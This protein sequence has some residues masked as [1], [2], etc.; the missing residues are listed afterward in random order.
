MTKYGIYEVSNGEGQLATISLEYVDSGLK[1]RL[2]GEIGDVSAQHLIEFEELNPYTYVEKTVKVQNKSNV[3]LP[4]QWLLYKPQFAGSTDEEDSMIVTRT[5]VLDSDTPFSIRPASGSLL[6]LEEAEFK[7]IFSPPLV[8]EYQNALHMLLNHL[9]PGSASSQQ[10]VA[11]DGN[12]IEEEKT[13]DTSSTHRDAMKFKDV[14]AMEIEVKGK[15]VPLNVVLHPYAIYIPG[16]TLVG[17]SVKKSF[18]M[19][20][21]SY[22]TITFQFEPH[23]DGHIVEVEPPCGDLDPGMAIDLEI[24]VTGVKPGKLNHTIYCQVLNMDQPLPLHVEGEFKGPEI[25]VE[26]PDVNFGLIRLGETSVR[27]I[28]L[29]NLSQMPTKW[30]INDFITSPTSSEDSMNSEEV[31]FYPTHGELKPLERSKV[32]ITFKPTQISTVHRVFEVEVEDGEKCS[33]GGY[34]EVQSPAVCFKQSEIK[35]QDVY[36]GVPVLCQAVLHNQTLMSTQFDWEKPNGVDS[37]NCSIEI[38]PI[39]GTMAPKEERVV[40]I[41]FVASQVGKVNDLKI[42]CVIEGMDEPLCLSLSCE[43]LGLSVTCKTSDSQGNISEELKVDFGNEVQLGSTP[44]MYLYICNQTAIPASYSITVENFPVRPPSPPQQKL[45]STGTS[46]R[47]AL[48]GR[49]PIV[50]DPMSKCGIRAQADMAKMALS[51][52]LGAG[53]SLSPASGNL[54]PYGEDVIEITGYSDIWGTYTDTITCTIGDLEPITF[55]L[56]MTVVGCPLNFQMTAAIPNQKPVVR[57]GTHVSGLKSV[58]RAMRINN[59]SPFDIRLDWRVFNQVKDDYQTLDL[60]VC[61]GRCFPP[62]DKDGSEII[63]QTEEPQMERRPTNFIPN[64]PDTSPGT[65]R[66]VTSCSEEPEVNSE[67]YRPKIISL[68][69][70]PHEGQCSTKPYSILPSQIVVPGNGHAQ[71]SAIFTPLLSSDVTEEIECLGYALGYM[72][73]DGK[74]AGIEGCCN[75]KEAYETSALRL[76]M[77]AQLKPALLTIENTDEEGMRYRSVMSDLIVNGETQL[78]AIKVCSTVLSNHT[79]T[80]LNF[81]LLVNKPFLLVD[82]D[83]SSNIDGATRA[84]ETLYNTLEPQHSL[85]VKVGFQTTSELLSHDSLK[86]MESLDSNRKLEIEDNLIIEFN[87]MAEQKVPLHATLTVP[88]IQLS[89]QSLDF[90]TCLVD[91]PRILEL[92]ISNQTSS[93][94]HWNVSLE[95]I[96]DSCIND[97]FKV[98][99]SQG[100]LDAYITHVSNSKSLLTVTFLAKHEE[101]YEAVFLFKGMLGENPQRL[102]ARGQGSYDG[103]HESLLNP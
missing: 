30:K 94:S 29:N 92:F 25:S 99:P 15:S 74:A 77:T 96:S 45:D 23:I 40:T 47:K 2:P 57:F 63:H 65:S 71:V 24:S 5:R 91:Q 68:F 95:S 38:D 35:P 79:G 48:L 72:S 75:R 26:E 89:K 33:V 18:T 14:T 12:N 4:F 98:E 67:P 7:L 16:K 52:G 28:T 83:P 49:T 50:P 97:T 62:R 36:V 88:Q 3:E 54:S 85:I 58:K 60:T 93:Q 6:P 55:P 64:S 1:E 17:S 41:S 32:T 69:L 11:D 19:A 43:V 42:P 27:E 101:H 31:Q 90:G 103:K 82:L 21:H 59:T 73:L 13:S 61:Y 81:R 20:N 87:N 9:P 34:G 76:D 22:S 51:C 78:E 8:G 84:T 53:F 56:T 66:Q 102:Y 37:E 10:S 44:R 46:L 100:I 86:D 39:S 70:N 80:P